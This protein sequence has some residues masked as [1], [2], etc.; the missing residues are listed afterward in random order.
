MQESYTE[1]GKMPQVTSRLSLMALIWTCLFAIPV[2]GQDTLQLEP[3]LQIQ[4]EFRSFTTDPLQQVYAITSKEELIKF[5]PNGVPQ[6]HYNNFTLGR[7]GHVDATNPFSIL[8]Y[9]P[10]FQAVILLD[11]TLNQVGEINLLDLDL[12]DT[13]AIG[14]DPDNFIWVY[15][16]IQYRIKRLSIR[17]EVILESENLA[18]RLPTLPQPELLVT[19]ENLIFLKTQEQ[20]T[21]MF[22]NF[23][24]LDHIFP[25][26]SD[27][28]GMQVQQRK[29]ITFP[30]SEYRQILLSNRAEEASMLPKT[31]D[32]A[33]QIRLERDL[34]LALFPESIRVYRIV[35]P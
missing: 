25:T 19:F 4:G 28:K 7:L 11:R 21:L 27:L 30:Q 20:G 13:Q 31:L 15:D 1:T 3:V 14:L 9:Y 2:F 32:T 34:L 10:D 17:G 12:P 24:R 23:G 33:T 22:D 16:P 6:F 8:L 29:L 18:L 26:A 5:G 35:T